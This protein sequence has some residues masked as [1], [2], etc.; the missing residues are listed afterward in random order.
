MIFRGIVHFAFAWNATIDICP[1]ALDL[2][3][4]SH[5]LCTYI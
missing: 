2:D 3:R 1:N 4:D 5:K